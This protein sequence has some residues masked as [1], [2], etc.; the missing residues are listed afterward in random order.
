MLVQHHSRPPLLRSYL[1]FLGLWAGETPAG[2]DE[3][4]TMRRL[5][6]FRREGIDFFLDL[7]EEGEVEPYVQLVHPW[8]RHVRVPL[9]PG[10]VPA[11]ERVRDAIAVVDGALGDGF[12]VYVHGAEG[13]ERTGVVVGCWLAQWRYHRCDPLGRLEQLRGVVPGRP[14]RSPSSR[15][16]RA[17]VRGWRGAYEPGGSSSPLRLVTPGEGG[18]R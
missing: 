5:R 6:G 17:L 3:T 9:A 14:N 4:D 10:A 16:G 13:V 1:V 2:R 8:A 15:A 18:S 12:F 7:T 11:E